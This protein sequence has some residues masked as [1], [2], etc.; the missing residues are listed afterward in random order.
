MMTVGG[1]H[2][3]DLTALEFV[4]HDKSA[5]FGSRQLKVDS[6]NFRIYKTI[7]IQS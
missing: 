2:G 4:I 6:R 7:Q 1:N 3:N 5:A